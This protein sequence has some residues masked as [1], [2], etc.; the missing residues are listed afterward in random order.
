[1][2]AVHPLFEGLTEGELA[3]VTA[4]GRGVQV[5]AGAVVFAEGE[6]TTALA[7]V[8]SGTLAVKV[9]DIEVADRPA[10]TWLGEFG[11][12][13]G[14][15]A[16][17]TVIARG[18]AQI[19]WM[20]TPGLDALIAAH[21]RAA[22]KILER[23]AE[24]V[25]LRLRSA[26]LRSDEPAPA[27]LQALWGRVTQGIAR[28]FG[29][30][31]SRPAVSPSIN[32][33]A[34]LTGL[35][36]ALAESLQP[37]VRE[38][39]FVDGEVLV[40]EGTP[41]GPDDSVWLFAEG[42]A[43]VLRGAESLRVQGR[44]EWSGLV[45]WAAG[46]DRSA[47]VR[48]AGSLRAFEIPLAAIDV[49]AATRPDLHA[50]LVRMLAAQLATDAALA[51]TRLVPDRGPPAPPR[52]EETRITSYGGWQSSRAERRVVHSVEQIRDV[53]LEGRRR[54]VTLR[55]GGLSFDEQALG[56]GVVLELEGFDEIR[57]DPATGQ[58]RVGAGARWGDVVAALEGTGYLPPILV[59][60]S[61]ATVG[62]TLSANSVSR[63][64]PLWGREGKSVNALQMLCA[65]GEVRSCS[66]T[67]NEDL[68]RAAIGGWGSLGVILSATIQLRSVPVPTRVSTRV[69]RRQGVEGLAAALKPGGGGDEE[70]V[71]SLIA[72][73]DHRPRVLLARARY[74]TEPIDAMVPHQPAS[75]LRVP[76]EWAIN[77]VSAA[78]QAFWNFAYDIYVREDRPYV[79]DLAGFT[80]FQDGNV[81]TR[82]AAARLG[83]PFRLIQQTFV[84]PE[85]QPLLL[86]RFIA[87]S[88][89]RLA[90]AGFHTALVDSLYLPHDEVPFALSSTREG[91][92]FVVT[93]TYEGPID[94]PRLTRELERLSA[95]LA[96]E[97]G[98]VHITKNV[99]AAPE[100]MERAYAPGLAQ[101]RRAKDHWDPENRFGNAFL[102]RVF[103]S[104]ARRD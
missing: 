8:E 36:R 79:D 44:G 27:V 24:Q 17:A 31:P 78:G 90:A 34:A 89:A 43:L 46:G 97:G 58:L 67:E 84:V 91:G 6:P 22:S 93:V 5:P 102:A 87:E 47:T 25:A 9:H 37:V 14:G 4:L 68:F 42:F 28:A 85:S 51:T 103:S 2:T 33:L 32:E 18:A 98:Y 20:D 12:L 100:L 26:D 7:L 77:Q 104:Y 101:W 94:F 57:F 72:Y 70:T 55:G 59:S 11:W 49:L 71:Y 40:R 39:R 50:A 15:R 88:E 99:F 74:S 19:T 3:V 35:N 23:V 62:G 41:V 63:F 53:L 45:A 48:A 96:Q 86:E 95:D 64:S 29:T 56:D 54:V 16:T 1:M 80:F 81:R 21:P 76:L 65:D 82:E 38:R 52:A 69:E 92:G 60:A 75:R 30:L 73:S 66:R 83:L 61:S 10:G 13:V